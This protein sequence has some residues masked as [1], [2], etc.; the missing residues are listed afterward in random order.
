MSCPFYGKGAGIITSEITAT[1]GN[2][3][4]LIITAYSPCAMEILGAPVDARTCLILAAADG[5]SRVYREEVR[6]T[7][8][9]A[10][11]AAALKAPGATG[12]G[13]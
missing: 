10:I 6:R 4:A 2:Q 12:S 5:L 1:G 13:S 8:I 3:C 11:N 9:E 7:Y